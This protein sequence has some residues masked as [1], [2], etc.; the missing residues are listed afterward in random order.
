MAPGGKKEGSTQLDEIRKKYKETGE[1]FVDKDFPANDSSLYFEEEPPKE[2]KWLR[3]KVASLA[4][5][6]LSCIIKL[7]NTGYAL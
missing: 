3:P 7:M 1:L 2:F 4:L 5:T 6:M